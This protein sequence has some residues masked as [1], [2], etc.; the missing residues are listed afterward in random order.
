MRTLAL[1]HILSRKVKKATM[2][3]SDDNTD[4][5]H[6]IAVVSQERVPWLERIRWQDRETA[7]KSL[8]DLGEPAV[9]PLLAALDANPFVP[10]IPLL[11]RTLGDIGDLRAVDRLIAALQQPNPHVR[12]AAAKA[13]ALLGDPGAIRPLIDSFRV[14]S[15]GMEDEDITAWQDAAKAL[16]S[17]GTRALES[18]LSCLRDEDANVRAW[19][20]DALGQAGDP[21]ALRPLV[22]ALTDKDRQVRIDAAV[23]LG[24]LGDAEAGDALVA[25]LSDPTEDSFVRRSAARALGHLIR[26]E[27]L[28]PLLVALDDPDLEVRCQAIWALAESGGPA[29]AE[30]LLARTTDP[31]PCV[32]HAAVHGLAAVGDPTLLPL[33][34]QMARDDTGA[35]RAALVRETAR[36][37]IDCIRLRYGR[38]EV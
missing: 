20:A 35:C 27:L 17:F 13:L 36:Y 7:A 19:S 9:A 33:L 11:I 31:E 23:A 29:A 16:A 2:P 15:D 4:I 21:H 14:Q 28:P 24:E 30:T 3:S 34:E 1:L 38:A 18:L 5:P 10:T 26:G 8:E 12:Q 32:R 22:S 6:L 37:A 25:R